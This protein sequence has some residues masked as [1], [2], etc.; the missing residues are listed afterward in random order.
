MS[1]FTDLRDS[2]TSGLG[3]ASGSEAAK[4]LSSTVAATLG[5]NN[6]K[7]EVPVVQKNIADIQGQNGQ[8][9]Q[10]SNSIGGFNLS[11]FVMGAIVFAGLWFLLRR[12]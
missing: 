6:V 12:K 3:L 11:P 2:V 8:D 7:Q 1:Y 9:A 4:T 10:P 5:S